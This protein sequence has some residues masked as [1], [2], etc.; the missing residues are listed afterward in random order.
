MAKAWTTVLARLATPVAAAGVATAL[1]CGVGGSAPAG[2]SITGSASVK[3]SGAGK[4]SLHEGSSGICTDA[5]GEG[6]DLIGL[7]GTVSGFKKAATWSL[8]VQATSP[9]SGTYKISSSGSTA[10]QLDPMVKHSTYVQSEK[11]ILNSSAGTFTF[12]GEKGTMDVTFGT[13][14]KAITVK[15]SWNC[16]G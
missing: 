10:G 14:S 5:R 13:G 12:K 8:V 4:G 15:G 2:A 3:L 11:A 7:V 16:G 9:K 6:V 1:L